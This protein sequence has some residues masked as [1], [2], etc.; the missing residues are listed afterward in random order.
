MI[1]LGDFSFVRIFL[2]LLCYHDNNF[3]YFMFGKYNGFVSKARVSAFMYFLV[4]GIYLHDTTIAV[5][6]RTRF[7]LVYENDCRMTPLYLFISLWRNLRCDILYT[8]RLQLY[9][10]I[11][12]RL[13]FWRKKTTANATIPVHQFWQNLKCEIFTPHL[14]E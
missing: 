1:F 9:T 14:F 3:R 8:I 11:R 6:W 7:I 13:S 2:K 4:K 5:Y 12:I 10:Y